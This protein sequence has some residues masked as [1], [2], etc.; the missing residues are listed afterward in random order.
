MITQDRLAGLL[1]ALI[2]AGILVEAQTYALGTAFRMGP[3]FFPTAV[4]GL[5][6]LIGA[7]LVIRS[8]WDP[9]P[10]IERFAWWPA[11]VVLVAIVVFA[12]TLE[13]L[14][15]IVAVV[16]LVGFTSLAMRDVRWLGV[17]VLAVALAALAAG[18]FRGLL[19][20]RL[21]LGF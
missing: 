6:V 21:P 2:G 3:G 14:G 12:L 18:L 16:L 15:L 11:L 10:R 7:L 5:L 1:F 8:A 20:M 9:G 17:A 13:R 4:G 19:G